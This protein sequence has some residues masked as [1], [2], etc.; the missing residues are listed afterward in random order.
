MLTDLAVMLA[1]GGE[2]ISDLAVLHEQPAL[3]GPVASTPTAW[4]VLAGID[5]DRL[6][7]L[8]A[9]RAA[10]RG[11]AWLA[12]AELRGPGRSIPHV[13]AGGRSWPG[14]VIDLALAQIP[15]AER[16]GQPILV[17]ADGAGA[18]KAWLTTCIS[19]AP[20]PTTGRG[21]WWTTRSGSP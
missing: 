6:S 4:Q 5:A 15:D 17:R 16:Y 10:A 18:T 8:R 12:R 2:A 14:P 13:K 1:D 11:R 9:S 21:C 20:R 7:A 19:F 3:F